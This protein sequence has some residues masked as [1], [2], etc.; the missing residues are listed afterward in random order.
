MN[1]TLRQLRTSMPEEGL[2]FEKSWRQSPEPF[3]IFPEF[4]KSL[5][6]LGHRLHQFNKACDL[7]YRLS[8]EGRQPAWIATFL[9]QGKPEALVELGRSKIFQG[10]TAR[11]IRPDLLLTEEGIKICELDQI[12]GGIGLTAWLQKIY[13]SFG[14]EVL[15]GAD[16][17]IEGFHSI[18]PG[19]DIVISQES[20][21]YRPEMQYLVRRLHERFSK[22]K[23]RLFSS[24]NKEKWASHVYRF[25][26]LFDV[27]NISCATELFKGA[28][29]KE[30]SI[31]PPLKPQ[32]EEKLWFALFWMKPLQDFWIRELSQRGW[33]QLKKV[34]PYTWVLN[35]EPLPPNA[36]YPRL[37][38][39]SWDEVVALSQRDR[40]L[41]IKISGFDERAWGSR[42]VVV[43][44][45]CSKQEWS[46]A[47]TKALGEFQK[48]PHILQVF[49]HSLSQEYSYFGDHGELLAMKGRV[50]LTPY[51]F[52]DNEKINLSG[53]LATICPADKKLLHGM[54]EA[55]LV[56]VAING[57]CYSEV[58]RL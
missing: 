51:Y 13:N 48:H 50:R 37:E 45:D 57:L 15:G 41:V 10:E 35:P 1:V 3:F 11:V 44:S 7:L 17:M 9:D 8:V 58:N 2:F 6:Q 34:I 30:I 23:W 46:E 42:S 19:G 29:K 16:G 54:S 27:S 5:D 22:K 24:D 14:Y 26:E 53:A 32:L 36:V 43:G 28:L 39:Q 49:H 21:T 40:E 47:L 55:I 20:D 25:F 4:K 38:A 56:P 33:E 52:I 12:P 31:T 18:L